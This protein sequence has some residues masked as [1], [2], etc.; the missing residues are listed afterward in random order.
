VSW[1]RVVAIGSSGN[2]DGSSGNG[3]GSSRDGDRPG[4]NGDGSSGNGNEPG[5]NGDGPGGK[6]DGSSGNGDGSSAGRDG[7]SASRDGSSA[8]RDGSSAGCDGIE[9]LARGSLPSTLHHNTTCHPCN[10]SHDNVMVLKTIVHQQYGDF[11]TP[12]VLANQT[13][14]QNAKGRILIKSTGRFVAYP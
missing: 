4:G 9:G 11:L 10:A 1:D 5:G 8:S 6:G 7:S 14:Y 13:A 3:D 2:G 12:F